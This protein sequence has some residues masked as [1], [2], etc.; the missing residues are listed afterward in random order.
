MRGYRWESGLYILED[1]LGWCP[2]YSRTGTSY[3]DPWG[4]KVRIKYPDS[5]WFIP[6]WWGEGSCVSGSYVNLVSKYSIDSISGDFDVVSSYSYSSDRNL[7]CRETSDYSTRN[8]PDTIAVNPDVYADWK[9]MGVEAY[10]HKVEIDDGD[11]SETVVEDV[12]WCPLYS[13]TGDWVD[14]G[15]SWTAYILLPDGKKIIATLYD[16]KGCGMGG[17]DGR[18]YEDILFFY[19]SLGCREAQGTAEN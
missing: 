11:G 13:K 9:P 16:K 8:Y 1:N 7:G 5:K 2:V 18:S 3:W 6:F 14:D 4:S 19:R 12:G 15:S 10:V 17:M